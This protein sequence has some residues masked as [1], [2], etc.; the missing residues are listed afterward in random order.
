MTKFL[1]SIGDLFEASFKVMNAAGVAINLLFI[2]ALAGF[3][4]YWIVK[5]VKNPEKGHH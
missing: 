2:A 3:A 4:V 5:M 1:Y